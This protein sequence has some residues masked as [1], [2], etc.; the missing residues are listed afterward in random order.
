MD[1]VKNYSPLPTHRRL[2]YKE[3]IT[4]G[5]I[6]IFNDHHFGW[7]WGY[8]PWTEGTAAHPSGN[9]YILPW[10]ACPAPGGLQKWVTPRV[11]EWNH[12]RESPSQREWEPHW[13]NL[14]PSARL[15][16]MR[17]FKTDAQEMG[18][19][20]GLPSRELSPGPA[21]YQHSCHLLSTIPAIHDTQW[22]SAHKQSL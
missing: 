6:D 9:S 12:E 7:I 1:G 10:L 13:K 20:Q 22:G 4:P 18:C 8:S 3:M 21:T 19:Q 11:A 2:S 15:W 5:C 16:F 17:E 14:S